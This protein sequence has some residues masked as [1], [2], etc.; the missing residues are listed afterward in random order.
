MAVHPHEAINWFVNGELDFVKDSFLDGTPIT[1][2]VAQDLKRTQ[3][4]DLWD[5]YV[6]DVRKALFSCMNAVA[7][8]CT[9]VTDMMEADAPVDL[10]HT[11]QGAGVGIWDGR[12]ER[13][14]TPEL[15]RK[16]EEYLT[17]RLQGWADGAGGGRLDEEF[18]DAVDRWVN[19]NVPQPARLYEAVFVTNV[20]DSYRITAT[21]EEEAI[22]KLRNKESYPDNE[23]VTV[24]TDVDTCTLC[25]IE[26]VP[27]D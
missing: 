20:Y 6:N 23:V 9:M 26:E 10:Y 19:A 27:N 13:W 18:A 22:Y 25:S 1:Y 15:I 2:D 4:E 5:D 11:L 14:L 12:W 17:I 16:A 8:K 21:S 24:K 3:L 7:G